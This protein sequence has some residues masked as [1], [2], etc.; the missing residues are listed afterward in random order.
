LYL[1]SDI[2][3]IRQHFC[4]KGKAFKIQGFFLTKKKELLI[5][6]LLKQMDAANQTTQG[7]LIVLFQLFTCAIAPLFSDEWQTFLAAAGFSAERAA[8]LAPNFFRE[9]VSISGMA[10]LYGRVDCLSATALA[11]Q[12]HIGRLGIPSIGEEV[13]RMPDY[14]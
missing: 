12:N 9:G 1:I 11:F 8:Q 3:I 7:W 10:Q 4:L 14:F 5:L 2:W 6:I 13:C